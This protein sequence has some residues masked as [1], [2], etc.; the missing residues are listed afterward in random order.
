MTNSYAFLFCLRGC[1][2][3][4]RPAFPAPSDVSDALHHC[5]T[6]ADHAARSRRCVFVS[7]KMDTHVPKIMA[8]SSRG[9]NTTKQ[10]SC[11]SGLS[12]P[13]IAS[14]AGAMPSFEIFVG[15]GP[16]FRGKDEAK[17]SRD[18]KQ[19]G[20]NCAHVAPVMGGAIRERHVGEK[21]PKTAAP[22]AS[23][24]HFPLLENVLW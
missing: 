7:A 19:Q 15:C 22:A 20:R 3:V 11:L 2:C 8:A 21:R 5:K 6:R 4:E 1:G 13:W 23:V 24:R 14:L 9:A 18:N 10:S 16:C 17:A 12:P